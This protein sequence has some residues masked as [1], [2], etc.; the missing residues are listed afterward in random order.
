MTRIFTLINYQLCQADFHLLP[1]LSLIVV[2]FQVKGEKY[3]SNGA[4]ANGA[5]VGSALQVTQDKK[6]VGLKIWFSSEN[7]NFS[8]SVSIVLRKGLW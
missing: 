5:R 4:T 7:L 6:Y 2:P 1:D 3:K 8:N